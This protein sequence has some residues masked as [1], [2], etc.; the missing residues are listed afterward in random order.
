MTT[1][2]RCESCRLP[3][4]LEAPRR[5]RQ[6]LE[7]ACPDLDADRLVIA[8]VLTGELVTNAVQHT[9]RTGATGEPQIGLRI[10]RAGDTLRVEVR[11]GDSSS[12][13]VAR[14]ARVSAESGR[15]LFLVEQL[16]SAW[17]YFLLPSG[18]GKAIWFELSTSMDQ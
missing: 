17:G 16:S 11:D 9:R 5:A 8:K 14:R 18:E 15:G 4:T 2:V 6:A 7:S 13:P 12:V 1:T 3:A 10:M